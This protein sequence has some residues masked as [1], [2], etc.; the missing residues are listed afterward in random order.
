MKLRFNQLYLQIGM[1]CRER[2]F[3]RQD[4]AVLN[5]FIV[6]FYLVAFF[7]PQQGYSE[8]KVF[9]KIE[10]NQTNGS[11]TSEGTISI[12]HDQ[13]SKIDTSSFQIDGKPL[14]VQFVKRIRVSASED[15]GQKNLVNSTFTFRIPKQ[16]EGLHLLAPISV[17]IDGQLYQS[18]PTSYEINPSEIQGPLHL[19]AEIMG[20]VPLYPGQRAKMVYRIFYKGTIDLTKERLPLIEAKGLQK[21]GGIDIKEYTSNDYDVQEIS[22]EIKAQTPGTVVFDRSIIEGVLYQYVPGQLNPSQTRIHAELPPMSLEILP[23]PAQGKPSSFNGT[24]GVYSYQVTLLS[25]PQLN[26]GDSLQLQI[27]V[28]GSG[29]MDTFTLPN[30]SC[31]PGFSGFFDFGSLPPIEKNEKGNKIFTLEFRPI[32]TLVDYIPS[33]EFSSFDP[34]TQRY[35][36]AKSEAVPITVT[37]LLTES[38]QKLK[39][40]QKKERL[41]EDQDDL[42]N[43]WGKILASPPQNLLFSN[44]SIYPEPAWKAWMESWKVLF[45]IPFGACF[46]A[47]LAI[48][49]HYLTEYYKKRSQKNS[50]DYLYEG[51]KTKNLSLIEKAIFTGL[52]EKGLISPNLN[53]IEDL[54][55]EGILGKIHGFIDEMNAARFSQNKE[56]S[57][58]QLLREGRKW[59]SQIMQKG[60]H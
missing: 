49:K 29:Q 10:K 14:S 24:I 46:L 15:N 36:T 48:L 19:T 16:A 44:R 50:Y 57:F 11:S 54:P 43:D 37:T 1:I 42:S 8:T 47:L 27:I 25:S 35:Y 52:R 41:E 38:N 30:I 55:K 59:H 31:Q 6:F 23:F 60:S 3:T 22:Q 18:T 21:I 33:I 32:S 28:S 53:S 51:L 58:D 4:T 12:I 45:L 26:L 5:F 39:E 13:K 20:N 17:K 9:A 34:V 2:I 56:D 7:I 40:Q